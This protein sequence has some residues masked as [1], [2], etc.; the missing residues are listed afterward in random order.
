MNQI[1]S[2][3]WDEN[4][5]AVIHWW[6][7]YKFFYRFASYHLMETTLIL[8]KRSLK[9][10]WIRK[11]PMYIFDSLQWNTPYQHMSQR[12]IC[13]FWMFMA[14][15]LLLGHVCVQGHWP[16][17]PYTAIRFFFD[18]TCSSCKIDYFFVLF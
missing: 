7:P 9:C 5:F 13:C 17:S 11:Y 3:N 15:K 14:L 10:V 18:N 1:A 4:F 2:R 8:W 16:L 6:I 12:A